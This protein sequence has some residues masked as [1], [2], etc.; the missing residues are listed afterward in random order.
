M[1]IL[2]FDILERVIEI[3]KGFQTLKVVAKREF[4]NRLLSITVFSPNL[5]IGYSHT[6][7]IDP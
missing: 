2:V 5:P 6:N 7:T 3:F 4:L 1:D